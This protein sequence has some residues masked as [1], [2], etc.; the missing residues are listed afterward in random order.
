MEKVSVLIV[1]YKERKDYLE[2]AITS[3]LASEDVVVDLIIT[4]VAGDTAIKIAQ[5]LGVEKIVINK[6]PGILEQLNA[7]L[8]FV[9]GEWFCIFSGNDVMMP[10]KLITEIT[11]ALKNK[12]KICYSA[13]HL[14]DEKLK[15]LATRRW[16]E[17]DYEKHLVGNFVHDG[18]LMHRSIFD[19]YMPY[20]EEWGDH[21]CWD[22]WLRVYKGEGNVFAYNPEPIFKYRQTENSRHIKR[23][24]GSKQYL[25][26]KKDVAS[27]LK[28][29][30]EWRQD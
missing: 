5:D 20:R 23:M 19:K 1:T 30:K 22:F 14:T 7:A 10:R 29:H 17:Y 28:H 13:F 3:C 8:S 24:K 25:K 11:C 18:A 27:M 21:F 15:V 26:R 12:K 9:E 16:Y 2:Q 6:E 4:T